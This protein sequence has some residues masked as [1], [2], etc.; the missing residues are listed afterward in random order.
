MHKPVLGRRVQQNPAKRLSFYGTPLTH[1]WGLR[2]IIH[3]IEVLKTQ[4]LNRAQTTD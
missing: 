3:D 1:P 2:D 4:S